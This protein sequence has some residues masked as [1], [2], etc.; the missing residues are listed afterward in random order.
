MI[1][2]DRWFGR[3]TGDGWLEILERLFQKGESI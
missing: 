2:A 3:S 1:Q